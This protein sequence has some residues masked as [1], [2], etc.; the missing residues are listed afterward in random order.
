MSFAF[1]NRIRLPDRV[2]IDINDISQLLSDPA[3][4][5]RVE[6]R[7]HGGEIA[8][9]DSTELVLT[10]GPY[11]TTADAESSGRAWRRH[12]Q[13]SLVQ[14]QVGA[15]F[16]S[17]YA[18][19]FRSTRPGLEPLAAEHGVQALPDEHGLMIFACEPTATF[20]AFTGS[21]FI[22]K[23]REQLLNSVRTVRDAGVLPTDGQQLACD[24][25]GASFFELNPETRLIL[26]VTAIEA[27]VI[28][29][30]R[31]QES[32]DLINRFIQDVKG[33]LLPDHEANSIIGSLR[34]L[35]EESITQAGTRIAQSLDG[36][37]YDDKTP[38]AF[39]RD[40]YKVRSRLVHGSTVRPSR[41]EV[42][43]IASILEVFVSNLLGQIFSARA[44]T[45]SSAHTH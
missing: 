40:A 35:R 25:F 24:L 27:L 11:A 34:D 6:L 38:E 20:A 5:H 41:N 16:G 2:R 3:D 7:S 1:R 36:R 28:R 26:L 29:E 33:G 22:P 19:L 12:L 45:Q 21:Y 43:R 4:E 13:A 10:G 23:S 14:M 30:R 42:D 15:D 37:V 17:D 39:F 31:S 44:T 9:S 8:I 18:P 32:T